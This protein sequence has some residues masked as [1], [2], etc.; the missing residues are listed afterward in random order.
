MSQPPF[1]VIVLA[2]G[3]ST[4]FGSPKQAAE[5]EGKPMLLRCCETALQVKPTQAIAVVNPDFATLNLKLPPEIQLVVNEAPDGLSSSIRAGVLALPPSIELLLLMMGDQP[6][7]EPDHLARLIQ[8]VDGAYSI[9]ASKY[10]DNA[11]GVPAAFSKEHFR[12]LCQLTGDTGAKPL[13][14]ANWENA[15]CVPLEHYQ[16]IDT[17]T[18]LRAGRSPKAFSPKAKMQKRT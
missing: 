3:K 11:P 9:A 7:V 16:D 17:V 12:Q 8:A 10:P 6:W 1:A 13:I 15:R 14:A 18:A 4:R 5:I 2:A